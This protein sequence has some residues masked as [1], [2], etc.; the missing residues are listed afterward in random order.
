M[1]H[2]SVRSNDQHV[3]RQSPGRISSLR[4]PPTE[5]SNNVF[6]S[7]S[8]AENWT[9][10]GRMV[11]SSSSKKATYLRVWLSSTQIGFTAQI[12]SDG[13]N[14]HIL[15]KM[16]PNNVKILGNPHSSL[17]PSKLGGSPPPKKKST[18]FSTGNFLKWGY[19]QTRHFTF[20][21]A[22]K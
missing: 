17:P 7:W 15:V 6:A 18:P 3:I 2:L 20:G 21:F 13:S 1:M 19:P 22:M 8:A 10:N 16:T 11:N 12:A 14:H 9:F 4:T 5:V